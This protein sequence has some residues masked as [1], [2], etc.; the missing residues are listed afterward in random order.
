MPAVIDSLILLLF[1]WVA[2]VAQFFNNLHAMA[3]V[4]L[5]WNGDLRFWISFKH[6]D[7]LFWTDW[8]IIEAF[9]SLSLN[10]RQVWLGE[11]SND[12]AST[13][14]LKVCGSLVRLL[15]RLPFESVQHRVLELME[16]FHLVVGYSGRHSQSAGNVGILFPSRNDAADSQ[17]FIIHR[18]PLKSA[19]IQCLLQVRNYVQRPPRI[20]LFGLG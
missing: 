3:L 14:I 5:C 16:D 20:R 18:L 13:L 19:Q 12:R 10:I 17:I 11:R 2:I 15:W 1:H 6:H 8:A 9:C 7:F 4:F